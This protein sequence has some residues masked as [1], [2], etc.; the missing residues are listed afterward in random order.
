VY[1]FRKRER[2]RVCGVCVCVRKREVDRRKVCVLE[3]D[4][5]CV[6]V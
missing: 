1:V 4:E 2:E 5:E 3:R 6:N